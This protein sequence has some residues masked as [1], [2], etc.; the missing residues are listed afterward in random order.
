MKTKKWLYI[1]LILILLGAGA[2][3]FVQ[4]S[5]GSV[6]IVDVALQTDTG[7][8]TGYL[9][10]PKSATA[11]HPAP[12]IVTS[13]GYLNNREMQDLNYVELSRRGYVVFAMNAYAHGNSSVA[14]ADG[15]AIGAA[16]GGMV[17]A[18][19]YLYGLSFVDSNKIGVTGHSMGGGFADTTASYYSGLEQEALANGAAAEEAAALNKVAAALI[20]G[21]A[22][23]HLTEI[24]P[25]SCELGVILGQYDEFFRS[26]A[27]NIFENETMQ[28]LVSLQAGEA[29]T[30]TLAEGMRY[31]NPE[32]GKGIVLY[33]PKQT[34]PWNHFSK[35]ACAHAIDFFD[36][37]L[38]APNPVA[39]SNQIWQLKEAFNCV[40]LIGFFLL[41][42]PLAELLLGTEFFKELTLTKAPPA[43]QKGKN[44]RYIALNLSSTLI[45]GIL[46]F[47]VLIIGYLTMQNKIWPQDTTGGIA[48]W[49]AVCGLVSLLFLRIGG[50]K[51]TKDNC[52]VKIGLKKIGKSL[53]LAAIV[54][55][56]AFSTVFVTHWLFLTDFRIWTF[57][58]TPFSAKKV[59]VAV[60]YLPFFLV[61]YVINSLAV[62]RNQFEG[63]SERKQIF[64]SCLWNVLGI[65][66]F[67]ALNFVPILFMGKT[68]L[69]SLLTD[70]IAAS[71]GALI[72]LLLIPVVPI[73]CIAAVVGVKLHRKTGNI[74]IA[75]F[76]N[77]MVVTML[78]VA[79]T[80]FSFPY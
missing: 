62:S 11:E 43:L 27:E 65:V 77:A 5:F 53:L 20:V 69:N 51:I 9:L 41:L 25:Y 26:A 45:A 58:V 79:N 34:H 38:G 15:P 44:S 55:A 63:W 54:S 40:A 42:V 17:D 10:V 75:G 50:L 35:I 22:P 61:Y 78:T 19:E 73:L 21:N 4:S 33:A 30:G 29:V 49:T 68:L 23:T 70:G 37:A 3:G 39:S 66:L 67:E 48:L 8:L 56:L 16:S 14:G 13:H 31:E 2:A 57:A 71:A 59:W 64:V 76:I 7:T 80:S 32:T 52:G 36:A 28:G 12:A 24:A 74:W 72:P 6:K 47:P 1:A 46:I 60:R 18:V